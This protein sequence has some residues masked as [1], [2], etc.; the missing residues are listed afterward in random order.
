MVR[1]YPDKDFGLCTTLETCKMDL[2]LQL[3]KFLE[4]GSFIGE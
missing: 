3:D 4:E 2:P 1:K